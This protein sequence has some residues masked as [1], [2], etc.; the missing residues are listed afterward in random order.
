MSGRPTGTQE[1]GH[2]N[3]GATPI[4]LHF[5]HA[6]SVELAPMISCSFMWAEDFLSSAEWQTAVKAPVRTAV[7]AFK[8]KGLISHFQNPWARSFRASGRPAAPHLAE[9][10]Q[11]HAKVPHATLPALL[12]L[13]GHN[14]VYVV[15]KSWA[16]KPLDSWAIIWVGKS[17]A[18]TERQAILVQE[19][20]GLVKGRSRFGIRVP[21]TAFERVFRQSRP[22]DQPPSQVP[23]NCLDKLGPVPSSAAADTITQFLTKLGW[24]TLGPEFWLVGVEGPPPTEVP[25]PNDQPVLLTPVADKARASAVIQA[26]GRVPSREEPAKQA[27][28]SSEE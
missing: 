1:S 6:A 16:H 20:H 18:D 28:A 13:S 9:T 15:P 24:Q 25:A 4:K 27:A 21:S 11:F 19:Q 8:A 14:K 12:K 3:M 7:D 26:G 10:F 5:E 23:I 22:D 17:R 2:H